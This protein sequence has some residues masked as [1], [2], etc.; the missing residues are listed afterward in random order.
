MH[1]RL[2]VLDAANGGL[3]ATEADHFRYTSDRGSSL[4][5]FR[6]VVAGWFSLNPFAFVLLAF[7]TALCLSGTTLVFVRGAR[8]KR[9]EMRRF[10]PILAVAATMLCGVVAIAA[11]SSSDREKPR[12]AL[13]AALPLVGTLHD[14]EAWRA[15]KTRFV[16]ESGRIV[17]TANSG[18]SHSEGQGYGMLLAV[19]ANDR[20]AFDTIWGWT[21]ANLMGARRRADRLA[22]GTE[23]AAGGIRH[24]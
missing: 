1:G 24:E 6:L 12:A 17:D 20:V 10:L 2:S 8:P 23:R 22:L 11:H 7:L 4:G 18:I 15:Y 14:P 13:D 9:C 3:V 5:N 19:A 16:T 21:R